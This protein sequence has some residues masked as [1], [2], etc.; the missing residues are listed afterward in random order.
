[1]VAWLCLA[2]AVAG[3]GSEVPVPASAQT[4]PHALSPPARADPTK[5]PFQPGSPGDG[6][7]S[8]PDASGLTDP[9]RLRLA[10]E[11]VVDGLTRPTGIA[12]AGDGS[13]RLFVV[14]QDG[15]VR[16]VRGGRLEPEPFL[17]IS[18]RVETTYRE[19]GLLAIAFHP[20]FARN[21]RFFVHYTA[22]PRDTVIAEYAAFP[23]A[24]TGD[25]DSERILL[26]MGRP[27]G[28]HNGGALA[29][30]PDGYL[31]IALG[32]GV[33]VPG[34]RQLGTG[35][36]P[37]DLF[38]KILRIDVDQGRDVSFD[39]SGGATP[40]GIPPDNPF[41]RRRAASEVWAIGLRNPW[42]MSFDRETGDLFIADVGAA[43]IEELNRQPADS[44]GGE[45]YGWNVM[46]GN[47][48]CSEAVMRTG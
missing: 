7:G 21:G 13:G 32:D 24:E 23:E 33:F 41:A 2:M 30:G 36:N 3:C 45:N 12:H 35:Q 16:V 11:R 34:G 9:P 4:T 28:A 37:L 27:T 31:Y 5:T 39:P 10:V 6:T 42:R 15:R 22:P 26:T 25:P 47:A 44:R 20:D 40:Y 19:Q 38:G 46:E 29:F 1:M 8:R 43:R 17:D 14:E 18:D 48:A